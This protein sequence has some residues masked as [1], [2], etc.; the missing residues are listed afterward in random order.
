MRYALTLAMIFLSAPILYASD[1]K[2]RPV[3]KG[4]VTFKP[5]TEQKDIPAKYRLDEFRFDY[6][7][8]LV[9]ELPESGV[10]IFDRSGKP[11]EKFKEYIDEY[12]QALGARSGE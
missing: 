3:E 5:S 9:R 7:M 4:T 8:K 12:Y 1:K 2:E 11:V 10:E 6:Q